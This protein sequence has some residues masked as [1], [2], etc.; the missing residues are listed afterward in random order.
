MVTYKV[1]G[2]NSPD[3]FGSDVVVRLTETDSEATFQNFLQ[4]AFI[5]FQNHVADSLD[6]EAWE[7]NTDEYGHNLDEIGYEESL[8]KFRDNCYVEYVKNVPESELDEFSKKYAYTT[9]D[10]EEIEW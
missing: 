7:E 5:S 10:G 6:G 3:Y 1:I 4:D 8:E 2:F 9:D